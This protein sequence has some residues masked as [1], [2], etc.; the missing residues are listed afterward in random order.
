MDVWKKKEKGKPS[1]FKFGKENTITK[2]KGLSDIVATL[3]IILLVIVAAGIMWIVIKNIIQSS[4]EQIELGRFELDL[5]IK[6]VTVVEE[7]SS[8]VVVVIRKNQGKG[9]LTAINFIFFNGT[10]T[11][12]IRKDSSLDELGEQT[13]T[14]VIT[15]IIGTIEKVSVAPIYVLSNG[16]EKEGDI[17][18]S[19]ELPNGIIILYGE[20]QEKNIF[21]ELGFSGM[22]SVEYGLSSSGEDLPEFRKAVVNPLDVY[23]GNNQTFTVHVYSPYNITEVTSVTE[24]DTSTL[25]LNFNKIDEYESNDQIIEVYSASWIV[26]DTHVKTYRTH[27]TAKDSQENENSVTLTW[28]DPCTGINH[29][30]DSTLSV[31][32]VVGVSEVSGLDGGSLTIAS[33]VT[34]TLNSGSVWAFNDGKSITVTGTIAMS[35]GTIQKGN[36]FYTDADGDLVPPNSILFFSTSPT[37][38]GKIRAKDAGW[39]TED[40]HD[41]DVNIWQDVAG[42]SLDGDQ[43]GWTA[44]YPDTMCAGADEVIYGRT[45]Y[46]GAGGGFTLLVDSDKL[47]TDDCDDGDGGAWNLRYVDSDSDG[48]CPDSN[49]YCVG[50]EGVE[51][52]TRYDDCCD[53]EAN[54]YVGQTSYFTTERTTCGGYDYNCDDV[55]EKE[56]NDYGTCYECYWVVGERCYESLAGSPGWDYQEPPVCGVEENYISDSGSSCEDRNEGDC[57]T[58]CWNAY[59]GLETQSCK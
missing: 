45:Y 40:C 51:S 7:N 37:Q 9:E 14:F 29:G 11:E 43:D 39:G 13:F 41:G 48:H 23:P 36:L 50:D 22:Q 2:K 10:N 5:E 8:E 20:E 55:Q 53:S 4:A 44:D 15:E 12:I 18:D 19:Y 32:C 17:L 49:T 42:L 46:E 27:V 30:Y 38:A 56:F 47:G 25:Y 16:K 34:L 35:G 33:G 52:C 24:L 26:N 31:N 58:S 6:S 1:F 59:W 21:E 28:T 57:E 54:A 3:I